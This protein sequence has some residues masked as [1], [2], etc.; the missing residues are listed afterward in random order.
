M[1][2]YSLS[3]VANQ[4]CVHGRTGRQ[5]HT[6]AITVQ[7]RVDLHTRKCIVRTLAKSHQQQDLLHRVLSLIGSMSK[8]M[9]SR[10]CLAEVSMSSMLGI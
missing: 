2:M 6:C 1:T 5:G 4:P 8:S 3:C 10:S 9:S 7:A